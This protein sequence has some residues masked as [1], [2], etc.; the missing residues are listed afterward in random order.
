MND[1][2]WKLLPIHLM[3]ETQ[4]VWRKWPDGRQES[5]FVTAQEYLRWLEEGNTP[6]PAD[7]LV[8]QV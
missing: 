4:V 7:E 5:C 8:Q 3:Q 6:I 1:P 2:V